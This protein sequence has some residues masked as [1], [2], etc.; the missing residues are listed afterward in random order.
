MKRLSKKR[1]ERIARILGIISAVLALL[2]FFVREVVKDD[3]KDVHD[4][5]SS[6]ETE[7][8][9]KESQSLTSAQIL[10]AQQQIEALT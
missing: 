4:S 5:I 6:A 2:T 8:R 9:S 1:K 3:L 7:Y 10:L